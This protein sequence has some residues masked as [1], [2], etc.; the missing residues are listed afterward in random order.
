MT[1]NI[2]WY[3]WAMMVM[4][5]AITIYLQ[6]SKI[7]QSPSSMLF[8]SGGDGLKNY[9]TPL[10]H[11]K[12]STSYNHFD[13]MNY[14]YGEH[15]LFTDNQPLISNILRFFQR[16]FNDVAYHTTG[17]LNI[18]MLLSLFFTGILLYRIFR[19]LQLPHWYSLP[20]AV[21]VAWL[22]PQLGR[23]MGHYALSYMII[24]LLLLY[25]LMRFENRA[26][27]WSLSILALVFFAPMLHFYYFGIAAVFLSFFYFVKVWKDRNSF[28]FYLKHWAIQLFIPFAFFNLIWLNIGNSVTD[29]PAYPS[30]F[31]QYVGTWQ[32]TFLNQGNWIYDFIHHYIV[33]LKETTEFESLNYIGF[34]AFLFCFVRFTTWVFSLKLKMLENEALQ[35]LPEKS[36]LI[37]AFWASIMLYIFSMGVPFIFPN[38]E[39]LLDY[40]GPLKQFRGL[41]R[42]SWMFYFVINIIAFYVVYHWGAQIKNVEFRRVFWLVFI[43]IAAREAVGNARKLSQPV[44]I[45]AELTATGETIEDWKPFVDNTKYQAILPIPYYHLGAEYL[46]IQLQGSSLAY[47]LLPSYYGNLP[48]MGVMMSRT[49]WQQSLN[50]I[51]LGMELY[52][53]PPVLKELP[54]Q[55]PLLVIEYKI[56]HAEMNNCYQPI[57]AKGKKVHENA[58]FTMYELP[59]D[60]YRNAIAEKGAT[61]KQEAL[62][63]KL[64]PHQNLMTKDSIENYVYINFDNTTNE[65]RYRGNGAL[66]FPAKER[67]TVF[68]DKIPAQQKG[69]KY[70]LQFW[71]H[72]EKG[73]HLRTELIIREIDKNGE[74]QFFWNHPNLH[75]VVTLDGQWALVR[76]P[77]EAHYDDT[78]FEISLENIVKT[79]TTMCI[80]ELMIYP[81][82]NILYQ[83]NPNET[84]RNGMWYQ[85]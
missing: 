3:Q 33:A 8:T 7:L 55:K 35:Q 15:V 68:F 81:E 83:V 13:N 72:I 65:V 82:W 32:G 74:Q 29:R 23:F 9:L 2:K 56:W 60:A 61:I 27:K 20:V 62:T 79:K 10:L 78:K 1:N 57:L 84:M 42:F 37:T 52:R 17:V 30:G 28:R 4:A 14:P 54:N 70:T 19:R 38:C 77:I 24:I 11:V 53:E 18:A 47:N 64:F 67:K 51:P 25:F 41:G 59:I 34:A 44:S 58:A 16:N 40:T 75:N 85:Y 36:F 49:S 5:M 80:D 46:G 50:S 12:N 71:Q 66:S 22:S 31:L 69:K 26:W 43:V 73:E 63:A 21:S 45:Y 39:F 48:S 76:V 6:F